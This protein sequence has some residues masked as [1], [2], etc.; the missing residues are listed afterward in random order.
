MLD[1]KK[2]LGL[3]LKANPVLS[4]G[5]CSPVR[6]KENQTCIELLQDLANR[7]AF[8]RPARFHYLHLGK[9]A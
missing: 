9:S 8:N 6:Y 7:V 3:L 4:E 2:A 5:L 1:V